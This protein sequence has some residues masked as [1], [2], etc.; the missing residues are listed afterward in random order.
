MTF[1]SERESLMTLH[2]WADPFVLPASLSRSLRS[3]LARARTLSMFSRVTTQTSCSWRHTENIVCLQPPPVLSYGS[4]I[5]VLR[6]CRVGVHTTFIWDSEVK[7][8]KMGKK[9]IYLEPP[10][11]FLN[12][13]L[14]T[15]KHYSGLVLKRV[16]EDPSIYNQLAKG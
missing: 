10:N 5:V 12:S 15:W 9:R 1:I 14:K 7:T 16:P 2:C 8:E 13:L 11:N 4:P 6:I 3:I